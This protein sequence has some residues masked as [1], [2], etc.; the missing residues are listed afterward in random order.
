MNHDRSKKAVHQVKIGARAEIAVGIKQ[1]RQRGKLARKLGGGE[2]PE[3]RHG[4][5]NGFHDLLVLFGLQR[6][7]GKPVFLPVRVTA[8]RGEAFSSASRHAASG[9]AVGVGT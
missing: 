5:Q 7:G 8:E 3:F 2:P 4:I 9:R 6:T 1:R